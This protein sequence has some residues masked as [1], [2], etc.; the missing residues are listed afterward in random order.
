MQQ[1]T[2]QT[3][4]AT[5]WGSLVSVYLSVARELNTRLS[6]DHGLTV[7]EYGVLLHLA[8]ADEFKLR[9]VDLAESLILSPSGITRMLD[10]LEKAGLVDKS[11]CETDARVTYAVLTDEGMSK[12]RDA[13]SSHNAVID[14]MLG[15]NLSQDQLETLT[16]LLTSLPGVDGAESCTEEPA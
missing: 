8:R 11:T 5:G 1:L 7:N 10:R 14:E 12:L 16:E 3:T 13:S 2:T 4:V 15:E 9:R 6:A